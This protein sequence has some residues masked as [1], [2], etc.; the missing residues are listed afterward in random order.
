[1]EG[2]LTQKISLSRKYF[3]F[4]RFADNICRVKFAKTVSVKRQILE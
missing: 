2:F 4:G 3:P 1:M